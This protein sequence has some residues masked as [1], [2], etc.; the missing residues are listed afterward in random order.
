VTKGGAWPALNRPEDTSSANVGSQIIPISGEIVDDTPPPGLKASPRLR[1]STIADCK[2]EIR[3]LYIDARNGEL[4][5]T[6]AGKFVW[7]ISTL[8]NLIADQELE[9][10]VARLESGHDG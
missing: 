7:I 6:D 9:E 1:L 4:S 5:S 2:R 8:A 3:R 10:R